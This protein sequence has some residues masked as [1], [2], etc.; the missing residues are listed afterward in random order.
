VLPPKRPD[1][2]LRLERHD[3]H[4]VT[5]TTV[6]G[7]VRHAKL[8]TLTHSIK[9]YQNYLI[10]GLFKGKTTHQALMGTL[11]LAW[12]PPPLWQILALSLFVRYTCKNPFLFVKERRMLVSRQTYGTIREAFSG[13][14]A[15]CSCLLIGYADHTPV[16]GHVPVADGDAEARS[17]RHADSRFPVT[18]PVH[19]FLLHV[20]KARKGDSDG[21]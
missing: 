8:P 1:T 21:R 11:S 10:T 6:R 7:M 13:I 4:G 2:L 19:I 17:R 3:T 18:E 20:C 5:N 14:G 16:P 9:Y 15:S 12:R